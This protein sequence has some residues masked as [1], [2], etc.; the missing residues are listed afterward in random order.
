MKGLGRGFV[1]TFVVLAIT[2]VSTAAPRVSFG[3][4]RER[5]LDA[6]DVTLRLANDTDRRIELFGGAIRNA[7]SKTLQARLIPDRR[8]LPPGSEHLWTWVHNGEAGRFVAHFRTSAGTVT[9]DFE[10]GTYFTIS[11]RCADTDCAAVDPFV[12]WVREQGPIG[13]LRADLERPELQR[14]I[15]SGIVGRTKPYNPAWSYSMG[16]ASIVLGEVFAEVCDAHP[17]YVEN[18]RRRWMGERWCPWS[19]FVSAEGR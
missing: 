10:L 14:R 11:F 2:S 12:I 6:R 1:A 9:D 19:S 8:Y 13:E 15:V 7:G 16:P 18:H 5:I 17:D 3:A 4:G